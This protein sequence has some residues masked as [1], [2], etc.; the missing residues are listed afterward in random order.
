MYNRALAGKEKTLGANH[1]STLE[2]VHNL[3]DLYAKQGRLEDAE[4]MFDR[5]LAGREKALGRVHTSTL[6]T[7]HSL[8]NVYEI[9]SRVADVENLMRDYHFQS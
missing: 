6:E 4:R 5:A 3:G 7:V 1:I 8:R 9:Q 2:T